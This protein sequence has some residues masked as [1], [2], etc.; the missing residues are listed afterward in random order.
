MANK[1]IKQKVVSVRMNEDDFRYLK[2][3]SCALGMTPSRYL[4]MLA[5]TSIVELKA[6]VKQGVLK[7]EDIEALLD[8]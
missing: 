8:D 7:I 6:K 3:C 5:D 4:R 2:A 1:P